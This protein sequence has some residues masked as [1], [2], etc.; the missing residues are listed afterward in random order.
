MIKKIVIF[1][2][3]S[4]CVVYAGIARPKTQ[5]SNLQ[6]SLNCATL[7]SHFEKKYG[8]PEKLLWA[9]ARVESKEKPWAV[10]ARGRSHFFSSKEVA[11]AH[12][13][14][15]KAR[16]VKNINVG[17]MQINLQSHGKRFKT[18]GHAFTPYNNI[19]YAAKLM[20]RLYD[21][22]GSWEEAVRY[23]HSSLAVHNVGYKHRVYSHWADAK[24]E[25]YTAAYD[26]PVA[27]SLEKAQEKAPFF[28]V[29]FGPGV[30]VSKKAKS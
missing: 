7:I 3:L 6:E 20:K 12:V 16:G 9:I 19:E 26:A 5:S 2:A 23:Y 14:K 28:K 8:I 22:H 10:Y 24:G 4:N 30:G 13:E 15:L 17:C 1:L 21:Q 11:I 18:L 29:G 25:V 27:D